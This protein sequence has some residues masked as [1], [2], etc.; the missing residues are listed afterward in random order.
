M[1]QE[2]MGL[3]DKVSYR[4]YQPGSLNFGK[5]ISKHVMSDQ[6]IKKEK[7]MNEYLKKVE[8]LRQEKYSHKNV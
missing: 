1:Y 6:Q 4:D 3:G 2:S 7:L 8:N 5:I